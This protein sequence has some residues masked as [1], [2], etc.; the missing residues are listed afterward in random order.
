MSMSGWEG[1]DSPLAE[2]LV[3]SN[4]RT[5]QSYSSKPE[6]IE[7]HAHIEE[8]IAEGGYG[9]RQVYELV[10]NGADAMVH[11][12]GGRIEVVLTETHLY[13]ANEGDPIDQ[14]GLEALLEVEYVPQAGRGDRPVRTW[15]QVCSRCHGPARILLKTC[16]LA[17]QRC[18]LS[19]TDSWPD[20]RCSR[21]AATDPAPG[22]AVGSGHRGRVRPS[23]RRPHVMGGYR[24]PVGARRQP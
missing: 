4:E 9:H 21:F 14:P 8:G 16:Q 24:R 20:T 17:F 10:Q 13:C 12:A 11:R 15:F 18:V 19:G 3:D 7:E 6:W 2:Y 5:L 22:R 1:P 23:P